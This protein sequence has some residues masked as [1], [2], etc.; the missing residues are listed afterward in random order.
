MVTDRL[1]T[2]RAPDHA[3]FYNTDDPRRWGRH[4]VPIPLPDDIRNAPGIALEV[5]CGNGP[6]ELPNAVSLLADVSLPALRRLP[7]RG[8]VQCDAQ[9]LPLRSESVDTYLTFATLEHVPDPGRALEEMHRVLRP[10]GIAFLAP[11]WNCRSWTATGVTIRPY[12][13][14]PWRLRALKASLLLRERLWWR[15]VAVAPRRLLRELRTLGGKPARLDFRGLTPNLDEYLC[16]D[17]DA[18]ASIDPHAAITFLRTR[19]YR[20]RSG[21]GLLARLLVRHAPVVGQKPPRS[22]LRSAET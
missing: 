10:G 22:R 16:S 21:Q 19:G 14:L 17:S 18:W 6:R 9:A 15:A 12:R 13:E 4:T 11:A 7:R 2:Q 5:G 1:K 8:R 3:S 20:I